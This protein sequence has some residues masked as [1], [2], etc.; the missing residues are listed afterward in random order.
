M[1]LKS[2]EAGTQ[3]TVW[4]LVRV[5]LGPL[6]YLLILISTSIFTSR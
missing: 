3:G 4:A 5:P 1:K 6:Q 2:L